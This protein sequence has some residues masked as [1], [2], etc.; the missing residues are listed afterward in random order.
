MLTCFGSLSRNRSV[1]VRLG[2]GETVEQVLSSMSEVAEGVA[3]APAAARLAAKYGVE[4]PII[5]TVAAV[6]AGSKTAK[7]GRYG[8]FYDPT[9]SMQ[10]G[11]IELMALPM[12][13][14]DG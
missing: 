2:K 4:T 9:Y 3:T 1:G 5:D 13:D 10:E 8:S 6:L 12:R 7:V 14:E 11:L